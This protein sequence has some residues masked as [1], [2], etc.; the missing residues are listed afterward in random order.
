M[1]SAI[2]SKVN[3]AREGTIHMHFGSITVGGA[4]NPP[5]ICGEW[6]M[7]QSVV[8]YECIIVQRC[9]IKKDE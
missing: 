6:R 3:A 1:A 9:H 8:D 4:S 7:D 2:F 5:L